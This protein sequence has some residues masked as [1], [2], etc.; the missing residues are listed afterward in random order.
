MG[1]KGI[2]LTKEETELGKIFNRQHSNIKEAIFLRFPFTDFWK[3]FILSKEYNKKYNTKNFWLEKAYVDILSYFDDY[4]N[5][6]NLNYSRKEVINRFE[7]ILLYLEYRYKSKSGNQTDSEKDSS[8]TED[9]TSFNCSSAEDDSFSSSSSVSHHKIPDNDSKESELCHDLY[10]VRVLKYDRSER[11][12]YLIAYLI[13]TGLY[14]INRYLLT[15]TYADVW[16]YRHKKYLDVQSCF[17]SL[18]LAEDG[19]LANPSDE[20]DLLGCM[21]LCCILNPRNIEIV[22]ETKIK[23]SAKRILLDLDKTW[24]QKIEE[25]FGNKKQNRNLKRYLY[26]RLYGKNNNVPLLTILN[27][28]LKDKN[29][30]IRKDTHIANFGPDFIGR[31]VLWHYAER[32]ENI[33]F[34]YLSLFQKYYDNLNSFV[35]TITPSIS[36]LENNIKINSGCADDCAGPVMEYLIKNDPPDYRKSYDGNFVYKYLIWKYG[37]RPKKDIGE[38][39]RPDDWE[40]PHD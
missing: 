37:K 6:W 12:K 10:S 2:K 35:V 3:I 28:V 21:I 18:K 36:Y 11:N 8:D 7:D 31:L 38:N 15:G 26:F 29:D 40:P 30:P 32:N 5:R 13:I 33:S 19:I 14:D 27:N 34:D 39:L 20:R 9:D 25:L 4:P 23:S 1:N 16:N 22:K 17:L 24:D